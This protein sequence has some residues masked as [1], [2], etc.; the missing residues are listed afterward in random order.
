M[1][2]GFLKSERIMRIA[3]MVIY[4]SARLK[5]GHTLRSMK[6]ITQPKYRRSI[7]LLIAPAIIRIMNNELGI[8]N[9]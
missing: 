3:P 8:K 7:K 1:L 9:F 5:I 2:F 4:A 6:S